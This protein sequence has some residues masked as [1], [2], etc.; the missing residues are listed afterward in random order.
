MNR[1][2]SAA[3]LLAC[4][5][6]APDRTPAPGAAVPGASQL[7]EG[8]AIDSAA[9]DLS[10]A[11][12]VW[13]ADTSGK[14]ETVWIDGDGRVVARRAGVAAAGSGGVWAWTEGKK[15]VTGL[16]CECLRNAQ[17]EADE[18]KCLQ[19]A[20]VTTAALVDLLSGRR[21][22]VMDADSVDTE[23]APPDQWA[24]P[25]SG[26]GPYL[27]TEV[28]VDWYACGAHGSLGVEAKVLDLSRGAA[29]VELV[30]SA[31]EEAI[32]ARQ[33]AAAREEIARALEEETDP[34]DERT[35]EL[36]EV[37]TRWTPAG[38]LEV[39]YQLTRGACYACSDGESSS[40]SHSAI[41][42]AQVLPRRLA[43]WKTAPE[44]VRRYW[45][46]TPPGFRA[47]W[48]RVDAADPAA[49]LARF[50]QP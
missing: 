6:C 39:A 18:K 19:Q 20:D 49:A 11:Y 16:D 28:R 41:H 37:E 48:S 50:R 24:A 12:L 26:V 8:A 22:S 33:G 29:P 10:D 40:Y 4:A 47:G 32:L 17:S 25:L 30:D 15:R 21:V 36:T 44:P 31:E 43:E 14:A 23:S 34:A 13:S 42:P 45:Q 9:P 5:A 46:A 7:K 35:L 38:A 27:F 2:L 1:R 3:L